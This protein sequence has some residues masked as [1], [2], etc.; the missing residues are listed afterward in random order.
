MFMIRLSKETSDQRIE[1]RPEEWKRK[2]SVLILR[3]R[4]RKITWLFQAGS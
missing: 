2:V 4:P 3:I 1:K